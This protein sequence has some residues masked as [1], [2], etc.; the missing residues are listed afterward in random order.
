MAE[1]N[2]KSPVLRIGMSEHIVTT[3]SCLLSSI[4]LGSC[5]AIML[6]DKK[7]KIGGMA[8]SV[9]PSSVA[10]EESKKSAKFVDIA[11]QIM[12][13]EF[14]KL[15]SKIEDI[16]AKLSG[17]ANMFPNIGERNSQSAKMILKESNV[18]LLGEDCGGNRGRSVSMNLKDGSVSIKYTD[19]TYK[20]I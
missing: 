9:L 5:V 6:Y 10:V 16:I 11:I 7:M 18:K 4:G 3:E 17:G 20:S 1:T 19:G 15:D 14:E 2:K 13:S 12:L 8:H